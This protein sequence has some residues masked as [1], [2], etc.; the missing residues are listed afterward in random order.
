[1]LEQQL[2]GR[3]IAGARGSQQRRG[4]LR[5]DP[6]AAAVVRH[7]AVRR[8]AL[9]L[10]VR[11]RTLGE[12]QSGDIEARVL[13]QARDRGHR[14][15]ALRRQRVHVDGLIERRAA[16]QVPL[17]D[18]GAGLDQIRGEIEVQVVDRKRQR[19]DALRIGEVDVRAAFHELARAIDAAFARGVQQRREAAAVHV[20]RPR[21]RQDAP[22][23]IALETARVGIGAVREQE[24]HHLGLALRGRPHERRLPAPLLFRVDVR[25]RFEQQPRR[26]RRCPSARRPSAASRLRRSVRFAS[27]PASSNALM[28]GVA[29]THRGFRQRV[30]AVVVRR[31]DVDARRDEPL[32]QS[33]RRRGTRPTSPSSYRPTRAPSRRRRRRASAAPP[34]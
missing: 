14:A 26:R 13:V 9:Q 23:P 1:M 25:T 12:Q 28:I 27:A 30:R 16:E 22:L 15:A 19:R 4:A 3:R 10:Q 24:P 2:H 17:V 20:L 32:Q 5:E 6:V 31:V 18:V 33:R 11:I 8:P 7:V 21:L 29:P 34:R